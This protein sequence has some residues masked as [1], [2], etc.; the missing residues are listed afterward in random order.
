MAGKFFIMKSIQDYFLRGHMEMIIYFLKCMEFPAGGFLASSRKRLFLYFFSLII[1]LLSQLGFSVA[2]WLA[3]N[4]Y[5][6]GRIRGS[7]Y[8]SLH[9]LHDTI[10]LPAQVMRSFNGVKH[11]TTL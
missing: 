1:F 8:V 3:P 4:S 7:P 10:R 5:N 9:S 6:K 2:I 11:I